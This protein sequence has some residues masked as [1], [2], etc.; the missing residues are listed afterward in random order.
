MNCFDKNTDY[1]FSTFNTDDIISS[2]SNG[3]FCKIELDSWR[4]SLYEYSLT[5]RDQRRQLEQE[6]MTR[7]VDQETQWNFISEMNRLG[8]LGNLVAHITHH[9]YDEQSLQEQIEQ[10]EKQYEN[11]PDELLE[12]MEK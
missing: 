4:Q 3:Y 10:Y 11:I 1:R 9:N 2:Y 8:E 6:P 5:L 12:L 7:V